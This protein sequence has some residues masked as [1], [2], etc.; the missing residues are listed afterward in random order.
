[1]ESNIFDTALIFEG[2][3]MR[4]SYT[5]AVVNAL[6]ENE[7]YFDNVYGISA[8]SSHTVNYLSRDQQRT[9]D[10][11][12]ESVT[13][14]DFGGVDTLLQ[15]KGY[16]NAKYIYEEA[17]KP[18][19]RLPFRF[20]DFMDNPAKAT[21]AAMRRDTGETVFWT[22]DDM[23]TLESMMV[24]VRA[25]STLPFFMTPPQIDG[26]YYYDGGLGEG[27]GIILDKAIRDGFD[28]FLIIRSRP[29]GYRKKE[30]KSAL[31]ML[32]PRR[33]YLRQAMNTRGQRYNDVCDEIDE[34]ERE[35]RAYVFYSRD[36]T[37]TSA[38]TDHPKLA[39][40]YAAGE[41]QIAEEMPAILDFLGMEG[42]DSGEMEGKAAPQEA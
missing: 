25:S 15:H 22:R 30:A 32:Y 5:A 29:R 40:N 39:A 8:G 7:L 26:Y 14:P 2:G 37:A 28:R 31:A 27:G 38:T 17:C 33:P 16:F 42:A 1:M 6:L 12:V 11:F 36:I 23:T 9:R 18:G 21:I 24:R 41:K 13:F 3:G 20:N 34:L 4:A 10:S 35:G 19:E